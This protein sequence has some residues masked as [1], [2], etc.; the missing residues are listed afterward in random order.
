MPTLDLA[1]PKPGHDIAQRLPAFLPFSSG[2]TGEP[3]AI[4]LTHRNVT[5]SRVL[6]GAATGMNAAS[7]LVHFIP[8]THVYGWMAAGAAWAA[9]GTV[10]LHR[11]YEFAQ[12]VAD[13]KRYQATALFG[14]SQTIIDL[15]QAETSLAANLRSLRFVNTG[16][17]PL[18]PEFLR[19]VGERFGVLVTTGYGLTEAAPVAHSTPEQPDLVDH[20]S[21]GYPVANTRVRLVDPDDRERPAAAGQAGEL[22]VQGPQV[23][24]GYLMPDGR[25]DRAAWLPGDW[26]CTGDLVEH[27]A[28]GRLR[29]VGRL[30]N[31]LKYKGYSVF[32][33]EL[34]ALI[35]QHPDVRDCVV[36]GRPDPVAGE[37]P[38]AFVVAKDAAGRSPEAI[39]QFV[40]ARV[41]PQKRIRDVVFVEEIPRSPAGKVLAGELLQKF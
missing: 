32:P 14:V 40:R 9:G 16:S 26:F 23:A 27:D 10:V 36:L 2:S 21:V 8:L 30:K 39:L 12:V 7:V 35:A 28:R 1:V 19:D 15:A 33:P 20:L 29:I 6:F 17:A 37:I 25:L 24:D 38:T 18:A 34:E 22:I 41:A 5:A 11:R 31:V 3:K 13:V 4:V